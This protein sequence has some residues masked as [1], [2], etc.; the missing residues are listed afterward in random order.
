[1]QLLWLER[2]K[3]ELVM[4]LEKQQFYL[5]LIEH[6]YLVIHLQVH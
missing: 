2:E 5:P 6:H 1:M 4:M 3:V